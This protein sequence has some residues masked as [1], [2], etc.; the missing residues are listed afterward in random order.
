MVKSEFRS[1]GGFQV[2]IV[3]MVTIIYRNVCMRYRIYRE[4]NRGDEKS[5]YIEKNLDN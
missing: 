2:F 4:A 5:S 1:S 3:V